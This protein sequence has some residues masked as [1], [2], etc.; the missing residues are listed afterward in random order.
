MLLMITAFVMTSTMAWVA[1]DRASRNA[2]P[3]GFDATNNGFVG[4]AEL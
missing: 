1:M 2:Q 4:F 3:K